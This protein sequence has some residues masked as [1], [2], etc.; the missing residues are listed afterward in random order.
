MT[1]KHAVQQRDADFLPSLFFLDRSTSGKSAPTSPTGATAS[2]PGDVP[3]DELLQAEHLLFE[4]DRRLA[5]G[6]PRDAGRLLNGYLG[7]RP[8]EL[9]LRIEP[10]GKRCPHPERYGE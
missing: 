10:Y 6:L 8:C 7:M 3:D 9:S 1:E 4:R 2:F 5:C